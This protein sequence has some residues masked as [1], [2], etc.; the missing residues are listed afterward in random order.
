MTWRAGYSLEDRAHRIG[1]KEISDLRR[2][3]CT[4]YYRREDSRSPLQ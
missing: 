3:D 2:F 1:Q 4:G